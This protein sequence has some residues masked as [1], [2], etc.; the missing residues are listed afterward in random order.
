MLLKIHLHK[1]NH[2][3]YYANQRL[4]KNLT[5][6]FGMRNPKHRHQKQ[7]NHMKLHQSKNNQVNNQPRAETTY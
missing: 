1:Q 5:F 6:T 2:Y 4:Y 7:N 3:Q